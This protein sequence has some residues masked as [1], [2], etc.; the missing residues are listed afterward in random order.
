MAKK[1]TATVKSVEK[2]KPVI[3][4]VE[5]IP[6]KSAFVGPETKPEPIVAPAE[7]KKS[8]RGLMELE[9]L[10]IIAETEK[11]IP[12]LEALQAFALKNKRPSKHFYT[13]Q[14]NLQ[15]F[16]RMFKKMLR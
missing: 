8:V 16:V 12:R 3:K 6:V 9:S 15:G 10:E 5:V 1:V 7:E 11:L 4:P 2:V 13:F 14:V